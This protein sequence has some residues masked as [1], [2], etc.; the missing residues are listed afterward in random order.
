[1]RLYATIQSE[2]AKKS[3]GGNEYLKIIIRDEN[4][5]CFAYLKIKQNNEV[6]T[7]DKRIII[8]ADILENVDIILQRPIQILTDD[9]KKS[10]KA[11]NGKHQHRWRNDIDSLT[12]EKIKLCQDCEATMN[13]DGGIID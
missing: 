7:L 3:Q 9:D 6:I 2:R 10:Q 1:M 13:S 12:G 8:D 11:I 5:H 4:K